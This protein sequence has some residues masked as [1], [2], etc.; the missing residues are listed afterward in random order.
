MTN[1]PALRVKIE[2]ADSRDGHAIRV[3]F[4]PGSSTSANIALNAFI[5][6][7]SDTRVDYAAIG[8][9]FDKQLGGVILPPLKGLISNGP[10][11]SEVS[12]L[13]KGGLAV[14]ADEYT[15]H[16]GIGEHLPIFRE[17]QQLLFH[18]PLQIKVAVQPAS[19]LIA[20]WVVAP[21]VELRTG[22]Y[23]LRHRGDPALVTQGSVG[24]GWLE[25]RGELPQGSFEI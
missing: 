23:M 24:D 9:L 10:R 25:D 20:W 2:L 19:F 13:L 8:L 7:E 12:G 6:N 17:Y 22:F 18:S 14:S 21:G 4:P 16:W 3:V 15:I 11:L 5:L 1:Q